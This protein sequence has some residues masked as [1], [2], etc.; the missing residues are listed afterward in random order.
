MG[1][2]TNLIA[3]AFNITREVGDSKPCTYKEVINYKKIHEI[4]GIHRG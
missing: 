4:G 3:F 1:E 2:G